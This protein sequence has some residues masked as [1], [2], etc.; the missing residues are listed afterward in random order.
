M[1]LLFTKATAGPGGKRAV[2]AREGVGCLWLV[3]PDVQ[4]LEA[5]ELR[6]A[7][8]VLID[9]LFDD[10]S[11]SSPPFEEISFNIGDLWSPRV[12]HQELP[13]KSTVGSEPEPIGTTK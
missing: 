11:V 12:V 13:S 1:V 5:F 4:S 7:E 8:W 3:D 2:C 10:A 9:T 6:G